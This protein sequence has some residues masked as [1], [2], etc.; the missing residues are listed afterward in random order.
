M[1]TQTGAKIRYAQNLLKFGT[2][3]ISIMPISILTSKLI[4]MKSLSTVR[5]TFFSKLNY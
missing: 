5:P 4:F 3:N 1:S 2:S